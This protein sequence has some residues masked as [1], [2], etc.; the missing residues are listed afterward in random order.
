MND[1]VRLNALYDELG[2]HT[3]LSLP[4][5]KTRYSKQFFVSAR[6]SIMS[7]CAISSVHSS[8]ALLQEDLAGHIST[9]FRLEDSDTHFLYSERAL[10]GGSGGGTG[11]APRP[12]RVFPLSWGSIRSTNPVWAFPRPV[13]TTYPLSW[14]FVPVVNTCPRIFILA[15]DPCPRTVRIRIFHLGFGR[16]CLCSGQ[17]VFNRQASWCRGIR[18]FCPR[19]LTH[20][21]HMLETSNLVWR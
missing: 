20:D 18:H 17:D 6:H 19:A 10:F 4:F 14:P 15:G 9:T 1:E 3:G 21:R 2:E 11:D 13:S 16:W 12:R 8:P 5:R 7:C